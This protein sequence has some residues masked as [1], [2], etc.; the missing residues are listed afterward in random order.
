MLFIVW[1]WYRIKKFWPVLYESNAIIHG[2]VTVRF[3][4]SIRLAHH[5]KRTQCIL[6]SLSLSPSLS[7]SHSPQSRICNAHALTIQHS[8]VQ[9]IFNLSFPSTTDF[10]D[11]LE[12]IL[13]KIYYAAHTKWGVTFYSLFV[14][15]FRFHSLFC[16]QW[17]RR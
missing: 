1:T 9:C 4:I 15:N 10:A 7:E 6:L 14:K 13:I 11:I 2:F 8:I 3:I 5:M 16:Q 17:W 12:I